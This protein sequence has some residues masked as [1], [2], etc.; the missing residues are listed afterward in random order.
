MT[1]FDNSR[2]VYRVSLRKG[3][4]QRMYVGVEARTWFDAERAAAEKYAH[5]GFRVI[6]SQS[7]PDRP[8]DIRA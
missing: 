3:V 2:E 4:A 8:I 5:A 6:G 7:E 1:D